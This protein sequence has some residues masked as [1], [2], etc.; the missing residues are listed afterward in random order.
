MNKHVKQ[1]L[2]TVTVILVVVMS[3]L[4][5]LLIFGMIDRELFILMSLKMLGT[6]VVLTAASAVILHVTGLD[7]R[8]WR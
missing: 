2:A 6:L 5:I 7:K 3:L 1:L 4:V 8:R